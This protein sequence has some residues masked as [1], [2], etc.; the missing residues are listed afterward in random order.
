MYA[1]RTSA[2][3]TLIV[4]IITLFF[5]AVGM[6]GVAGAKVAPATA[7]AASLPAGAAA[8]RIVADS[9]VSKSNIILVAR[10]GRRGVSRRHARKRPRATRRNRARIRNR[11]VHKRSA[12]R[13]RSLKRR[14]HQFKRKRSHRRAGKIYRKRPRYGNVYRKR[15][16]Y[17]YHSRRHYGRHSYRNRR[18]PSLAAIAGLIIGGAIAASKRD[19]YDRWERCDDRYRTF[20]WSDGTYIPYAGSPR[21]L[22]PYLRR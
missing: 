8:E 13:H 9:P 1:H 7:A 6:P 11:S 18:G 4:A 5:A 22:C 10:K 19:Y 21:V 12:R 15:P 20:R 3:Q 17:Q 14:R 2:R 16:R